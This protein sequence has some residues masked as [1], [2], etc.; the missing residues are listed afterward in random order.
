MPAACWTR[1]DA[2]RVMTGAAAAHASSQAQTPR[3]NILLVYAD[4]L[5]WGDVSFNGRRDWPTPNLDRLAREGTVFSRWYTGAPLCAPSRGCLLTGKYTIHNGVRNNGS[6]IPSSEVTLAEALKTLGYSTALCGKWHGGRNPTHPLQQGFDTTFG[7]LTAGH[8]WEHFPK[9]LFRGREQEEVKGFS[10]DILADEA[11][12]I[13]RNQRADPFFI[14]LAFIEPH[15]NI[16]APPEDVAKLEGKF[17]ETDPAR[18]LNATYA[19]MI[20]RMDR[21]LGRVLDALDAKGIAGNT[22]VLFTSDNGATFEKGNLGTALYHDSNRPF[23]GE[24]R[25]L[26][27]GGIREPAVMRWPGRI[28]AGRRS[29][30]VIHMTDVMPSLLAAAGASADPAWKV[31]G[32]NML[33][34][35][36]G[37]KKAPERTVFWEYHVG[38]VQMLAAMRGDFKLLDIAGQQFLYNVEADPGERRNLNAQ[39][40]DVMKQLTAE[41]KAWF[42][43]EVKR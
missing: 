16:E 18:P 14:Y 7:Y 34:V 3:P 20:M 23:R 4:D 32:A 15:F 13:I 12:R 41:L 10:A 6:D 30:E 8:A 36:T 19:A 9:H 2:L 17:A 25:S 22:I 24:K 29:K 1:R 35:W 40:P 28:P 27:E 21:A 33:D 39:Y 43:T 26:E 31:D 38:G 42:A 5:G 37:K 11:I